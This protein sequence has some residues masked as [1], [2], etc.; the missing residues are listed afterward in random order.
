MKSGLSSMD[1]TGPRI[2]MSGP[3]LVLGPIGTSKGTPKDFIAVIP[4]KSM[5]RPAVIPKKPK[6]AANPV[7][8]KRIPRKAKD[9]E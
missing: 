4:F 6:I 7:K 9:M 8:I 5:K 3:L 1:H 2:T